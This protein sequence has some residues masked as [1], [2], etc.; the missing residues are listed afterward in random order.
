MNFIKQVPID[1]AI[2][3]RHLRHTLKGAVTQS[4]SA[5][6]YRYRVA[7]RPV[8]AAVDDAK[9]ARAEHLVRED[10]SQEEMIS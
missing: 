2:A 5:H 4:L 10:L 8:N 6:L 7:G 1:G 3:T 9:L